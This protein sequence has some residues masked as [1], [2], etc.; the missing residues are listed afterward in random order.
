VF[1]SPYRIFSGSRRARVSLR[2]NGSSLFF[3]RMR[4]ARILSTKFGYFRPARCARDFAEAFALGGSFLDFVRGLRLSHGG[5][6]FFFAGI[7]AYLRSS[8]MNRVRYRV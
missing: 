6:D 5:G 8:G 1:E 7:R 3:L 2:Q 4:A